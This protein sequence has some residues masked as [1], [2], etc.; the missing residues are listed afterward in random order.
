MAV[1][2][3]L[4]DRVSEMKWRFRKQKTVLPGVT[5]RWWGKSILPTSLRV[6]GRRFGVSLGKRGVN[7]SASIPGTGV[8]FQHKLVGGA[9]GARA[10][11]A[12]VARR[13][14]RPSLVVVGLGYLAS[15]QCAVFSLVYLASPQMHS[16]W[17]AV[18]GGLASLLFLWFARSR[19]RLRRE[20]RLEAGETSRWPMVLVVMLAGVVGGAWWLRRTDTPEV[21]LVRPKQPV[22][23]IQE[24]LP[25][26]PDEQE[27]DAVISA[28]SVEPVANDAAL[29]VEKSLKVLPTLE[30]AEVSEPRDL[31]RTFSDKTGKFSVEAKAVEVAEG[32]VR[33][34]RMDNRKIISVDLSRLSDV[35]QLWLRENFGDD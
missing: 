13:P 4:S 6:G 2:V 1:P 26:A 8:S 35:D 17:P 23:K 3:Q 10:Q 34:E 22:P 12:V 9:Q 20:L 21:A 24:K 16:W 30:T 27:A 7:A 5:V 28:S 11:D 15:L 19:Q 14:T 25:D 29:P 18:L 32:K 31:V 33:L